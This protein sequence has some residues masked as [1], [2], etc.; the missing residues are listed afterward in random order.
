MLEIAEDSSGLADRAAAL[1]TAA[2]LVDSPPVIDD[3]VTLA[4]QMIAIA[5]DHGL[6]EPTELADFAIDAFD[7]EALLD[8]V[9]RPMSRGERQLCGLLLAFARPFDALFVVDPFAGLDARRRRVVAE[10]LED[11]AE[12]RLIVSTTNLSVL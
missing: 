5:R 9:P 2:V 3:D 1:G 7:C 11:L 10:I 8:R 6:A 4:A 12:D